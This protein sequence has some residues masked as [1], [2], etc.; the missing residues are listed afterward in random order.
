MK[1]L[2]LPLAIWPSVVASS[3]KKKG[4]SICREVEKIQKI[5]TLK[6]VGLVRVSAHLPL[7][8]LRVVAYPE[9]GTFV[10]APAWAVLAPHPLV[11]ADQLVK[12]DRETT[13]DVLSKLDIGAAS[14]RLPVAAHRLGVG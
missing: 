9:H 13:D 11:A 2:E 5:K 3:T 7:G 8:V 6:L 14:S 1:S 10:A 4:T 12:G